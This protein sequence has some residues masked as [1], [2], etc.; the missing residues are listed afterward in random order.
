MREKKEHGWV[1]AMRPIL[2]T[3]D[4]G[5]VWL[6]LQT[7][8]FYPQLA[9][10]QTVGLNETF[11]KF[12]SNP[13]SSPRLYLCRRNQ[14]ANCFGRSLTCWIVFGSGLTATAG[15]TTPAFGHPS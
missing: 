14:F 8:F 4:C 2:P 9:V 5:F 3:K 11:T 12:L 15:E 6:T 13:Q 10:Y 1:V 7:F